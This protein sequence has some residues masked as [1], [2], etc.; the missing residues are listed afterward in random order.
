MKSLS[1]DFFPLNLA[2]YPSSRNET[3]LAV[4]FAVWTEVSQYRRPRPS[5]EGMPREMYHAHSWERLI[6]SSP[7]RGYFIDPRS[8][9]T[10]R[11]GRG[12]IHMKAAKRIVMPFNTIISI[13]FPLSHSVNC[14]IFVNIELLTFIESPFLVHYC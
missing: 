3:K 5:G 2:A 9:L 4:S 8:F 1:T 7:Q 14:L 10:F 12:P 13:Y 6:G 11:S